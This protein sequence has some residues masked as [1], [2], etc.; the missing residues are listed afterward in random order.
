MQTPELF[1]D[2]QHWYFAVISI[3]TFHLSLQHIFAC[4][5]IDTQHYPPNQLIQFDNLFLTYCVFSALVS[6]GTSGFFSQNA[7]LKR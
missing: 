3:L 2:T 6:C 5:S 1:C 4:N 7:Q